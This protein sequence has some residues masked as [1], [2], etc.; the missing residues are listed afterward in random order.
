MDQTW[1]KCKHCDHDLVYESSYRSRFR[2]PVL[3]DLSID[4]DHIVPV[5]DG[6]DYF[7]FEE[8]VICSHCDKVPNYFVNDDGYVERRYQDDEETVE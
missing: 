2:A 5:E 4:E 1:L 3:S 8:K 6:E 7:P